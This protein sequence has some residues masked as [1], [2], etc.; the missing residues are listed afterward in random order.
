[1]VRRF[2]ESGRIEDGCATHVPAMHL[3]PAFSR[4]LGEVIPALP[5][6]G[7]H[8]TVADLR[9]ASAATLAAADVLARA[10]ELVLTS[11]S[12]LRGGTYT[13]STQSG[14]TSAD[15]TAIAWTRD[16]FVSGNAQSAVRSARASAHLTLQGAAVGTIDA[17]WTT[18]G[19][20]ALAT[21][22]G[23]IGGRAIDATMPAP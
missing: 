16:L 6:A 17:T 8:G 13:A 23:T 19:R 2:T 5:A 20:G 9:A 11:G 21:I 18:A 4:T 12:G 1:M 22:S 10:Y 3:T 14:V 15:L 7:N